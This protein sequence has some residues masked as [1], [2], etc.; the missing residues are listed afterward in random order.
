MIWSSLT[1]LA[2]HGLL[3]Y[4]DNPKHWSAKCEDLDQSVQVGAGNGDWPYKT[5]YYDRDIL[6]SIQAA[7]QKNYL[8]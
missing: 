5:L 6:Q 2:S 8:F 7:T 4:N 3:K 1:I